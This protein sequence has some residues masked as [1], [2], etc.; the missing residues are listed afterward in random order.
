MVWFVWTTMLHLTH[1]KKEPNI[2]FE[3]ENELHRSPFN[4]RVIVGNVDEIQV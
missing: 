3:A 4:Q 1:K 2:Y